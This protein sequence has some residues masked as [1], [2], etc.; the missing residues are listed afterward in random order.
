MEL[1]CV[2]NCKIWKLVVIANLIA[3]VYIPTV[4][5]GPLNTVPQGTIL[6]INLKHK[7]G[8]HV[9]Y[10]IVEYLQ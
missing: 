2:P 3:D 1:S 9:F 4:H 10:Q 6:L 7:E 5:V 8:I